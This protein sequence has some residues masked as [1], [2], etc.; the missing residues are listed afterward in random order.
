[1]SGWKIPIPQEKAKGMFKKMDTTTPKHIYGPQFT[2]I[3][4]KIKHHFDTEY[5]ADSHIT[6][7]KSTNL[8]STENQNTRYFIKKARLVLT[9][10]NGQQDRQDGHV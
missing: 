5:L 9:P 10:L 1:V 2:E 7:F 8:I 3:K 6:I 4:K